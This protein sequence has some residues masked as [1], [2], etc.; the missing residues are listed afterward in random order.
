M[1]VHSSNGGVASREGWS[2]DILLLTRIQS[3]GRRGNKP[4]VWR[5]VL[6]FNNVGDHTNSCVVV[7]SNP[8]GGA[9]W[10][11][12]VAPFNSPN[13]LLNPQAVTCPQPDQKRSAPNYR[14]PVFRF[15]STW[16]PVHR[17]RG[18]LSSSHIVHVISRSGEYNI[19]A[20]TYLFLS[21]Q[22]RSLLQASVFL[23]L[24]EQTLDKNTTIWV[25]RIH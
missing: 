24:V 10:R 8:G 5:S 20:R 15:S 14:E 25:E 16:H 4:Q 17:L 19:F 7:R 23:L 1:Q 13:L 18:G 11:N 21:P 12:D 3:F 6:S 2:P 9:R 22:P